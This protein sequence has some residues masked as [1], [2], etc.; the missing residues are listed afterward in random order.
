MISIL[1]PLYNGIQYLEDSITSILFQTFT[2]WEVIIGVNGY[3]PDSEVFNVASLYKSLS[4]KIQVIDLYPIKGKSNSLNEMIKY[5]KYDWVA[6]LDV[7]DVW[8]PDKL[9][10]QIQFINDYDIIGGECVY[11]GKEELTGIIPP[12]PH[13]DC[14]N[15]D[16]FLSNPIINSSCLIKKKY[17]YWKPDCLVEDYELW[18]RLKH[19]VG[20]VKFY[21]VNEVI[22]KHRLHDDSAF[23]NQNHDLVP[24]L[25]TEY[26][27]LTGYIEPANKLIN[28]NEEINVNEENNE[29]INNNEENNEK[30]NNNEENN[31]NEE[32][33]DNEEIN[34]NEEINDNEEK[35]EE[36]NDNEEKNEEINNNEE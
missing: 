30:I 20:N 24:N 23:N 31:N 2:D 16:F 1:I 26:K 29:K 18:L 33:N 19:I 14:T 13:G 21:N 9:E 34:N 32:I 11:F 5:A 22:I 3:E 17:C 12:I 28:N 35:N 7:D 25:L 27:L 8:F 6:L 15:I 10:K 4:N 36:I